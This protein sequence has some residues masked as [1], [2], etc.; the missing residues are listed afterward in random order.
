[1]TLLL[2]FILAPNSFINSLH[3]PNERFSPVRRASDGLA[4]LAKYQSHLE[5]IYNQTLQQSSSRNSSHSSLKQ[6]QQECQ[7]LQ[8]K[9][10]N[11]NVK[12]E[13]NSNWNVQSFR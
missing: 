8:V 10:Y 1:M 2:V 12:S 4:N 3:L 9:L 11:V 13:S 5:K 6:L 7:E